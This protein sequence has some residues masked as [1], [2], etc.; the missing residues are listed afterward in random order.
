MARARRGN[1]SQDHYCNLI[2]NLQKVAYET[3]TIGLPELRNALR[4]LMTSPDMRAFWSRSRQSRVSITDGDD[5]Q[6]T[7]TAEVDAAYTDTITP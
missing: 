3:H 6:D 2:L 1:D 7:F 5:A 4:F